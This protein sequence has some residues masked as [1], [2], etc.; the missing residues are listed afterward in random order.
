MIVDA[1]NKMLAMYVGTGFDCFIARAC[2]ISQQ[3]VSAR[4]GE[5]AFKH[6]QASLAA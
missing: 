2:N 4:K 3:A 6:I 1:Y 5:G